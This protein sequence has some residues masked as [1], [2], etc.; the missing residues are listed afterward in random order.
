M[1]AAKRPEKYRLSR[2]GFDMHPRSSPRMLPDCHSTPTPFGGVD[3]K[4]ALG[5]KPFEMKRRQ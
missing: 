5:G 4:D 3:G 1:Q 2:T